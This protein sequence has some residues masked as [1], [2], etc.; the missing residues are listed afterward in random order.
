MPLHRSSFLNT[1]CNEDHQVT[2]LEKG[3]YSLVLF[4]NLKQKLQFCKHFV[5]GVRKNSW[6]I[7]LCA[8]NDTLTSSEYAENLRSLPY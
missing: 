8:H 1:D 6:D 7:V 3:T 2:L 4:T 5:N